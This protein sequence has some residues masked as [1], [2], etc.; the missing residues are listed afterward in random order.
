M[1]MENS[2]LL[3]EEW[4]ALKKQV[5]ADSEQERKQ[6]KKDKQAENKNLP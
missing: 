3:L 6:R 2:Q 4:L 5:Q 1:G